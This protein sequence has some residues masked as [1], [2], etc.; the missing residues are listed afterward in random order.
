M[1]REQLVRPLDAE[2]SHI[3]R[4]V[5][6]EVGDVEPDIRNRVDR[7]IRRVEHRVARILVAVPVAGARRFLIDEAQVVAVDLVCHRLIVRHE[8]VVDARALAIFLQY[9]EVH[10]RGEHVTDRCER[11]DARV[12]A[13][14]APPEHNVVDAIGCGAMNDAVLV[15]RLLSPDKFG[16]LLRRLLRTR[17]CSDAEPGRL[18]FRPIDRRP[19]GMRDH[20]NAGDNAGN[21]EHGKRAYHQREPRF[22]LIRYRLTG[23]GLSI[24]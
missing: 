14:R 4:M 15:D 10:V 6:I 17:S 24:R 13:R 5:R 8:I 12:G 20:P 2:R 19:L 3:P 16:R 22:L 18:A 23:S 21:D 1:L 11:D 7:R 9:R